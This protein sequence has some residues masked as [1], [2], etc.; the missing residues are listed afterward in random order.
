MNA[1]KPRTTGIRGLTLA[2]ATVVLGAM[3]ASD[4]ARA[5]ERKFLVMLANSP[6]Q[7]P[8]P[9]RDPLGQPTGGL[10]NK[11]LIHDQYFDK[12]RGDIG[13]F[14]EYWEEI[15]YGD[16]TISGPP[17][18][19]AWIAIPW[20]IQPMLIDPTQDDPE[21]GPPVEDIPNDAAE[22]MTPTLF[23]DA[24]AN[25]RYDYGASEPINNAIMRIIRDFNGDPNGRDDG[26]FIAEPGSMDVGRNAG[27]DVWK[28]GERFVDVDGDGRWDGLDEAANGMDFNQDGRPDNRG[29]WIDLNGDGQPQAAEDCSCT[30]PDEGCYLDDS[31][32]D[33]FPDCCPD[34]PGTP[35]CEP[36][37]ADGA[38][39]PTRW[40]DPRGNEI[41]DC[42]GNLI[43]DAADIASGLSRDELPFEEDGD[44]CGPGDGDGI[45]DECQVADATIDCREEG[46]CDPDQDACCPLD[47]CD[48]LDDSVRQPM[49]RCEFDDFN[50]DGDLDIV[51]PFENFMRRWD[52]CYRDPDRSGDHDPNAQYLHWV[53]VYDPVS[54]S[55]LSCIDP[56][57]DGRSM[58]YAAS[59]IYQ[60]EEIDGEDNP[61]YA[62]SYI[63]MNYPGTIE[64][65]E[66]EAQSRGVF[67]QHDPMGLVEGACECAIP[68]DPDGD[69]VEQTACFDLDLN[70]NDQIDD[71]ERNLCLAGTHAIYN[72]SDAWTDVV[73]EAS[74]TPLTTK[75]R[76]AGGSAMRMNYAT[77]TPEPGSPVSPLTDGNHIPPEEPWFQQAWEDRY[78]DFGADGSPAPAWPT[79]F[80]P[81][82]PPPPGGEPGVVPNSPRF[83]NYNDTINADTDVERRFFKANFGGIFGNGNGWKGE[84]GGNIIF[85]THRSGPSSFEEEMNAPILPEETGGINSA[86]MLYDGW[87]EHDDLP[88]SKSHLEGDMR[89]GEVTS[90]FNHPTF[91]D[92]DQVWDIDAIWGQ[93]LGRHILGGTGPG[94]G[95]QITPSAG[96]YAVNIHGNDGRDAGNM[97]LIEYLTW[98]TDGTSPSYGTIWELRHGT[99]H[100]YAGPNVSNPLDPNENMGFM[101]YNLDGMIDQGE[102]RNIGSENYLVDSYDGSPNNGVDSIYPF[103]RNRLV[104]DVMEVL[105]ETIDFD[106]FVDAN[107]MAR[108][109]C[110]NTTMFGLVPPQLGGLDL[111][112]ANGILSGIVLLPDRAHP[113]GDFN[114]APS[115][116][117][118][119]TQDIHDP[120]DMFPKGPDGQPK[121]HAV[122]WSLFVHDL[123]I[124]LG[125]PGESP[126]EEIPF[127]NFQTPFSAHEYGHSWE[128]WP[129]L[130]DYDVYGPPGPEIN[131]PVGAWCIMA[132]GGLVHPVPPLKEKDCTEWIKPVDLTTILTPGVSTTLTMP[133]AEFVRDKSYFFIENEDRNRERWYFWAAGA[134]TSFDDP[135][136]EWATGGMPGAGMLILHSDDFRSNPEGLP[137]Q[138][139]DGNRFTYRIIQADGNQELESGSNGGD[140]GDPFP[141]TEETTTLSLDTDPA[142]VWYD[143]RWLGLE[144]TDIRPDGSG[145]I[146]LDLSWTPTNIPGWSFIDPPGGESV[147]TIYKVKGRA[148]DVHGGTLLRFFYMKRVESIA[149]NT[150]ADCPA[151]EV[152]SCVDNECT[153]RERFP[154]DVS[155]DGDG[156]NFVG[157][158]FKLNS[159]PVE[160]S[161]D[162]NLKGVPDN[163]Y[164]LVA[165]MVPGPGADGVESAATDPRAGRNNDGDGTLTIDRLDTTRLIDSGDQGDGSGTAGVVSELVFRDPNTG[166]DFTQDMGGGS[167]AILKILGG[168]NVETGECAL[169]RVWRVDAQ[170]LAFFAGD[171][172]RIGDGPYSIS[173]YEVVFPRVCGNGENPPCN[174][175]PSWWPA[176]ARCQQPISSGTSGVLEDLNAFIANPARDF[177]NVGV[178]AGDHLMVDGFSDR[179][180]VLRT[181]TRILGDRNAQ[182]DMRTLELSASPLSPGASDNFVQVWQV[183]RPGDA[184]SETW[185]A[186]AISSDGSEWLVSSTISLPKPGENEDVEANLTLTQNQDGHLEGTFEDS[187]LP[188]AFTIRQEPIRFN[189]GSGDD[190][191]DPEPFAF[192][193]TFTFTTTGITAPSKGVDVIGQT[194]SAGPTAVISAAPLS[195]RAPLE[196]TFD[197]RGSFEP[198]GGPLNYRWTFDDGSPPATGAVVQHTFT[199]SRTFTVTLR[200]TKPSDGLFDEAFVDIEIINNSPNAFITADPT[201]GPLVLE[202]DFDG[203]QSS[204]TE[205]PANQLIYEWDFGD[206]NT[207]GSG[208]PGEFQTV[209]HFYQVEGEFTAS[210]TVTDDG[211]KSDLAT[212]KVLAGNTRPVPN[213]FHSAL[214]GPAPHAVIFNAINS[215]DPDGDAID[216]TW[217][218]GDGSPPE[219]H[220]KEGPAGSNTGAVE[221]IFQEQG[222]YQVTATL[223]DERGATS[224]WSGVRVV[225]NDATIG[226]SEPRAIFTITPEQPVLGETFE[227]DG[228]LSFDRPSGPVAR[229]FWDFGDG[230]TATGPTATHAYD[231]PGDYTIMLT[232][233]DDEVPPNSNATARLVRITEDGGEDPGEEPEGNVAPITILTVNPAEGIVGQ[234]VFEFDASQSSD[235]DGDEITYTFTFGD[236]ETA[237]GQAVVTHV[238]DEPGIYAARVTVRDVHGRA[239]SQTRQVTVRGIP[240]NHAPIAFITTGPVTGTAPVRLRFNGATS[241][242]PDPGDVLTYRWEFRQ[243]GQLTARDGVLLGPEVER[244]FDSA[245]TYT[246]QLT[247]KDSH[248]AVGVSEP[249]IITISAR[250]GPPVDPEPPSPGPDNGGGGDSAD[251]RPSGFCGFGLLPSFFGMA[252]ALSAM[253]AGRRRRR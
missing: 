59:T 169:F 2:V 181:V 79:G 22:R 31:D 192:G 55:V 193:D 98:R 49:E 37:P 84:G 177:E 65:L 39:P 24:N 190:P 160:I 213:I 170:R 188:V 7:Y 68:Y 70:G 249:R 156:A 201:S 91:D 168:Q 17:N 210:L 200:V 94:G 110:P 27:K 147:G 64:L 92:E 196:V 131:R 178:Q 233:F 28:P 51:E 122:S 126:G 102:V 118:I 44:S 241:I 58:A 45:P 180:P 9:D 251:Q 212:V 231:E 93:D 152:G 101:D 113:A 15:S 26:P 86:P 87:V 205:T 36:Y 11:K 206:G 104:E 174:N 8:G 204:D 71:D 173:S 197:G 203:S 154:V 146:A 106:L 40:T 132:E 128:G 69:G 20:P 52:P 42:N 53:K 236:G 109:A 103:N 167:F 211:G 48:F 222:E 144:V 74:S 61:L 13:S 164:F 202:V 166:T 226:P 33:R 12:L 187:N 237:T 38:C 199:E 75:I 76:A 63:E 252:L 175:L 162:W 227:V 89:F 194:I 47:P 43:D 115:F 29:P 54:P 107:A 60:P 16:V 242:D 119:H 221:H 172:P 116:V 114:R 234:T 207:A 250:V 121:D 150:D 151:Q 85:E 239:T 83:E 88:S 223:T 240:D 18:P 245:G 32:N 135:T 243:N 137:P 161:Q 62:P 108:V 232:V 139:Q 134:P 148:N 195:G 191:C 50:G 4:T 90:P 123:V 125:V 21:S 95:D 185:V 111:V 155:F 72:P 35:G 117:P 220:P 10:I 143:G 228:R 141:G 224:E 159:G 235:P 158:Q 184:R 112:G 1:P 247:V 142:A 157:S 66:S 56:I 183:V 149:C 229:Y 19:V 198:D 136:I 133:G 77:A 225:V 179:R 253:M 176:G 209:Q 5:A 80:D 97:A 120:V 165:D 219:T 73:D 25:G 182:D 208:N 230:E 217:R 82:Q 78:D 67:G 171:D 130:Y 6:K 46:E 244:L 105:D 216:V 218:W 138:Q 3:L 214:Q 14:A 140:P 100:P 96:P 238:Y 186:E 248:G 246:V 41:I 81:N 215:F 30:D 163:R 129:D 23:H 57:P 124:S 189:C 127:A 99:Q 153:N 145:N 34:G